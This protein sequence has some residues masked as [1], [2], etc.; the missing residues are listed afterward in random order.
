MAK[1]IIRAGTEQESA[2]QVRVRIAFDPRLQD[3]F[4]GGME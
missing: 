4:D 1:K 3:L 2:F